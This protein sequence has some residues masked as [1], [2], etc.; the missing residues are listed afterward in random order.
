IR[1][2]YSR[3]NDQL[4]RTAPKLPTADEVDLVILSGDLTQRA[5]PDEFMRAKGFLEGLI[6][7]L[8]RVDASRVIIVPSNHDVCWVHSRAAYEEDP[9][10]TPE[11]TAAAMLQE[12]NFRLEWNSWP[13]KLFRRI[14][15][16]VGNEQYRD[17]LKSFNAFLESFYEG[18]SIVAGTPDSG[19]LIFDAFAEELG[20]VVV[21]FSSC[22]LNDHV[23]RRGW[24]HSN[25][26]LSA[27]AELDRRGLA[28]DKTL[29][30]A[31]WHHNVYGGPD[32]SDFMDPNVTRLMADLGFSI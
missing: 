28:R 9:A 7:H 31:V 14:D 5:D 3:D 25:S 12:S 11:N 20:I 15:N 6:R 29:R 23:W 21:G 22:T 19:Y 32:K 13:P 16:R 10:P 2:G 8:P 30:I 4:P 27:A 1:N 17:R 24:I 26:I 18:S